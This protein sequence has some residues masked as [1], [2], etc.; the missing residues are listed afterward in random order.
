MD[1]KEMKDLLFGRLYI[2]LQLFRYSVL[3]CT[4]EE[5]YSKSFKIETFVNMYE[6]LVEDAE[7]LDEEIIYSLLCCNEGILESL[8]Q[9]WLSKE[10]SLFEELK[11]Y[12]NEE[13]LNLGQDEVPHL[14]G[15]A[16][17]GEWTDQ[18]A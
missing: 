11:S 12:I 18:A 17:D 7:K 3:Q 4:K 10:D 2:E 1:E 6:I 9:K 15:E 5:I 13:L 8:Y 16:E 14:E